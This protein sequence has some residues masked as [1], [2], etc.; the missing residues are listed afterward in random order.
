MQGSVFSPI[1]ILAIR[2]RLYNVGK[3]M[4][5]TITMPKKF[6][7]L[8]SNDNVYVYEEEANALHV[9]EYSIYRDFVDEEYTAQCLSMS[10]GMIIISTDLD[11]LTKEV[12]L[13]F[14]LKID[15]IEQKAKSVCEN[16]I[17]LQ[18]EQGKKRIEQK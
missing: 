18:R 4:V 7:E 13:Y 3:N 15:K 14:T 6:K 11:S 2:N 9:V 12:R 16:I 5:R 10:E 17:K 8:N 1:L